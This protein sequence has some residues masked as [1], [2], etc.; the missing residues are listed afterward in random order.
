MRKPL[1]LV[2]WCGRANAP[3]T[4]VIMSTLTYNQINSVIIK[5]VIFLNIIH[6][7]LNRLKT[8]IRNTYTRVI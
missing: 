8:K 1:T 3:H 6:T 4:R 7:V 5:N 2:K